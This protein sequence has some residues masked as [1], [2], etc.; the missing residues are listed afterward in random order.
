[1]SHRLE[2]GRI[3]IR[4]YG[5]ERQVEF[6]L[7]VGLENEGPGLIREAYLNVEIQSRVRAFMLN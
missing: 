6:V 4:G 2:F 1:M 5:G 7:R 3:E